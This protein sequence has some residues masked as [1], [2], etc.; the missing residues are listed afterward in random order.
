MDDPRYTN[1]DI[2]LDLDRDSRNKPPIVDA[3]CISKQK[4]DKD[5]MKILRDHFDDLYNEK[6]GEIVCPTY[7]SSWNYFFSFLFCRFPNLKYQ[8][9]MTHIHGIER[10]QYTS[11]ENIKEF[12]K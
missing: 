1:L 12:Y 6:Y 2:P 3:E 7:H 11:K 10:P 5:C 9:L 8:K 4:E